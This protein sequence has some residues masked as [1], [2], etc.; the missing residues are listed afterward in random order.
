MG[1]LGKHSLM[2]KMRTVRMA[3]EVCLSLKT[4]QTVFETISLFIQDSQFKDSP[5][6]SGK[7]KSHKKRQRERER[8]KKKIEHLKYT[9]HA[10]FF[11]PLH[12]HSSSSL[13]SPRRCCP[14]AATPATGSCDCRRLHQH[15][16]GTRWGCWGPPCRP[17][18][19]PECRSWC[20]RCPQRIWRPSE[21]KQTNKQT[22]K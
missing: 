13:P 15:Q 21:N 12:S 20:S 1:N 10:V 16:C 5:R 19:G 9:K 11:Y 17:A 6:I 18:S 14:D 22:N 3:T 8:E 4:D 7:G 2:Q